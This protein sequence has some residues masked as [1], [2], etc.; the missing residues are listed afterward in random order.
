[1]C[2]YDRDPIL[3]EWSYSVE[4]KVAYERF[5]VVDVGL[6]A[7]DD[8]ATIS[9]FDRSSLTSVSFARIILNVGF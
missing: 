7:A 6:K 5:R 8:C 4:T 1:M 3:F 2:P 9:H